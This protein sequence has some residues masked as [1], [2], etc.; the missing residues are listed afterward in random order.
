MYYISI[1][2]LTK[3]ILGVNRGDLDSDINHLCLPVGGCQMMWNDPGLVERLPQKA[4]FF[5][6]TWLGMGYSEPNWQL[7]LQ[8]E[9]KPTFHLNVI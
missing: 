2:F 6:F 9:V 7:L 4:A 3:K 5:F 1:H 8:F